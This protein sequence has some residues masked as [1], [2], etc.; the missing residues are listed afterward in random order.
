M[1][2]FGVVTERMTLQIRTTS[3]FLVVT[4][5]LLL[6]AGWDTSSSSAE[7]LSLAPHTLHACGTLKSPGAKYVLGADVSSPSTCFSVQADNITL[8]LGGHTITY[9]TA[10]PARAAFG[11]LGI[12]CWDSTLSNGVANGNPCGGSFNG[13]SLLHGKIVQAPV[14]APF[15]DAVHFGQ[16]GG[17]HLSVHDMEIRV[18]G[19]SA[20]PIFTTYSGRGSQIYGNKIWNDVQS[21]RNRH[22]LQGMSVKFDQSRELTPGQTVH[23]NEITGGAQGGILLETPGAVA[24]HNKI[25][26][27]GRYPNDFSIYVWGNLQQVYQNEID[28]I[29]GRGIQIAG[30]AIN[31]GG[32]G[33]GGTHSEVRENNINV[34]EL[35]Q[36]CEYTQTGS[37]D[38]CQL[39]GAYGIQFDDNPQGDIS[40]HNKVIARADEC[41]AAGLR[42]TDSEVPQNQSQFDSFSGVRVRTTSAGKAY[43]WDNAGPKSF[44]AKN[45]SFAG[46]T[47]SYHVYWDGAENETCTSCSFAKGSTNP[48]SNY[49]TFSFENGGKIPARN[50]HFVD[51]TFTNGARKDSTN[52]RPIETD[53]WPGPAEY[54]ID[55][56]FKLTVVDQNNKSVRDATVKIVDVLNNEVYV[57]KTGADGSVSTVLTEF[58]MYNTPLKVKEE[59]KTPYMLKISKPACNLDTTTAGIQ[60]IAPTV[61][62]VRVNC[63]VS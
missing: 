15:S 51:S 52:M 56:S 60:V 38:G 21:I 1:G 32:P 17:D 58:R 30:G 35:K 20:I 34:I 36:N 22:Q 62:T 47:A 7:P 55:W 3:A 41:D 42:V 33:K 23:D 18:N 40:S 24:F 5:F 57:A 45:D 2:I 53:N 61:Q 16:G 11:V 12:A 4:A 19:D 27:N 25:R 59:M 39:G 13:F 46:D 43:G 26:Q 44:T 8:D 63:P 6:F 10:K 29:S 31:T 37:C 48:S 54:F 9:G 14:L 50:I 28:V 49:V